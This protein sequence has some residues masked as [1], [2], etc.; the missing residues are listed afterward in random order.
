MKTKICELFS[1]VCIVIGVVLIALSVW[2][3][4]H[5]EQAEAFAEERVVY[6]NEAVSHA[7]DDMLSLYD[8]YDVVPDY[9]LDSDREM[10][11]VTIDDLQ[12]IGQVSIPSLDI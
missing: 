1:S 6:V 2:T 8:G 7:I 4:V 5:S 12:V 3:I 10:P 11:V 9:V